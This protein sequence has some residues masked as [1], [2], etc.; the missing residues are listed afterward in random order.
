MIGKI[1]GAIGKMLGALKAGEEL[2][3]PAGWKNR[4]T[5]VNLLVVV[6][7]AIAYLATWATGVPIP[8]D[9]I[10]DAA[11]AIAI[12]LGLVNAYLFNAT[13]KKVGIGRRKP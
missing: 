9:V 13:S 5:T 11:Q 10:A 8:D 4:A 3:N 7:S 12:T 6:L 1:F 2:S